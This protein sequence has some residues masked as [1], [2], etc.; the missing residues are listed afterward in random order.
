MR[1]MNFGKT[2]ITMLITSIVMLSCTPEDGDTG[3]VGPVGPEGT[4]GSST[5]VPGP[6]GPPGNA[7]VSAFTFNVPTTAWVANGAAIN[8]TLTIAEITADV[9]KDGTIQVF[10]TQDNSSP[11]NTS[12]TGVPYSTS[13][14][15]YYYSYSKGEVILI[16]DLA[17][18][19]G[20]TG[21]NIDLVYK[22][23]VIPSTSK[24]EGVDYTSLE[25][26]EL[27]HNVK[28]IGLLGQ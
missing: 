13:I 4:P 27:V 2:V 25:E 10:Q 22:V 8:S 14:I 24:I 28:E 18:G 23:V 5:G 15:N 21:L 11:D 20:I 12:W 19:Q 9:V 3:P 7:N 1:K 6:A 26:I 16:V 17:N